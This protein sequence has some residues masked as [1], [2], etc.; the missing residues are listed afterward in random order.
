MAD[1]NIS[2]GDN[3]D[4]G[5]NTHYIRKRLCGQK[6]SC[7]FPVD[8]SDTFSLLPA[9]L[10]NMQWYRRNQPMLAPTS[11]NR[12]NKL[13]IFAT[14]FQWNVI[15][16][17]KKFDVFAAQLQQLLRQPQFNVTTMPFIPEPLRKVVLMFLLKN[18]LQ[19]L[20]AFFKIYGPA[21]VGIDKTQ[22]PKF[23]ALVNVGNARA[24]KL[25]Q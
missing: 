13:G 8:G 5:T 11:C 14:G 16:F 9:Q 17:L 25:Q 3:R 22:V 15:G 19:H 24:D 12:K 7:V 6:D 10:G 2:I 1:R 18:L 20:H 23:A 21:I 4:G